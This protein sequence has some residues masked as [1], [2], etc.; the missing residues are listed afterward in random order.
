MIDPKLPWPD[1]PL[2]LRPRLTIER[3][4]LERWERLLNNDEP[5]EITTISNHGNGDEW[6]MP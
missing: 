6:H 4:L 1:L 3:I 2:F 5:F